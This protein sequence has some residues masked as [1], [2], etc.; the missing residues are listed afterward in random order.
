ML[1]REAKEILK[2]NG[3]LIEGAYKDIIHQK[4]GDIRQSKKEKQDKYDAEMKKRGRIFN[5][6]YK[7]VKEFV[8]D[9]ADEMVSDQ[10]TCSYKRGSWDI[11]IK[12]ENNEY[13]IDMT[14]F[15]GLRFATKDWNDNW[16]V[17]GSTANWDS[18]PEFLEYAFDNITKEAA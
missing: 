14:G 16:N 13:R 7:E 11:F 15:A 3:Y 12:V 5:K 10:V 2:K 18:I 1:L 9:L 17:K 8:D 6:V 4:F